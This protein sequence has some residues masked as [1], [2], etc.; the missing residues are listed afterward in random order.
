MGSFVKATR[1]RMRSIDGSL[2][3]TM[4]PRSKDAGV[5]RRPNAVV[6][7]LEEETK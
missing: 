6:E 1:E 2:H 7:S 5:R 3:G 4:R